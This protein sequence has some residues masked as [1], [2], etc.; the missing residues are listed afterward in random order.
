MVVETSKA[1]EVGSKIGFL[2]TYCRYLLEGVCVSSGGCLCIF[3]RVSVYLRDGVCVSSG[4]CLCI[5]GRVSVYLR[6]GVRNI[7]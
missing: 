1:F 5:F 4:G 7:V 3:G 2:Y 6:A